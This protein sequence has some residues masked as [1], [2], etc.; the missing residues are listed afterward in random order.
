MEYQT[1]TLQ[2]FESEGEPML[3]KIDYLTDMF[4]LEVQNEK[5]EPIVITLRE[6]AFHVSTTR[7]RDKMPEPR[8]PAPPP[9]PTI[10]RGYFYCQTC[11]RVVRMRHSCPGPRR[12]V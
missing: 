7:Q 6:K 11:Q 4:D 10:R 5:G 3:T 1:F 2:D 12:R 8:P 9:A